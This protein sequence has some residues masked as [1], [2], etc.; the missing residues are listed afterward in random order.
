[1]Q[2][3]APV[4]VRVHAAPGAGNT[5][6]TTTNGGGEAANDESPIVPVK[7]RMPG[8]GERL[9]DTSTFALFKRFTSWSSGRIGEEMAW[10]DQEQQRMEQEEAWYPHGDLL[11]AY[12]PVDGS[13]DNLDEWD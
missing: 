1:M 2:Q 5:T 3:A 12:G 6:T 7:I 11:K 9:R 10:Y 4:G 13:Y 8:R